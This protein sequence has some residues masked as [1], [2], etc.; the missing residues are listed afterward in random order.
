M[1]GKR[2]DAPEL[3]QLAQLSDQVP[4]TPN[5]ACRL[6]AATSWESF[7]EERWP[8]G[9][10]EP[11]GTLRDASV[12]EPTFE[13]FHLHATRYD[14]VDAPIAVRFFPFNRCDVYRCR[15]CS[16]VVLRYTEYG[17]YYVDHRLRRIVSAAQ[18]I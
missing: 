7:T 17:G 5:C 11:L 4:P 10:M 16:I 14:S 13:E 3:R 2:L 6:H 9:L 8:I 1:R 12:D 18:V 15:R